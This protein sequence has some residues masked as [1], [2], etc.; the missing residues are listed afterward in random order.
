[1]IGLYHGEEFLSAKGLNIGRVGGKPSEG[2]GA[3]CL[4]APKRIYYHILGSSGV[5]ILPT[6]VE[7]YFV[8]NR[9]Q[10]H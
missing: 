10:A 2:R 7:T 6:G 3:G 9:Q 8:K 5:V 1:M 4:G